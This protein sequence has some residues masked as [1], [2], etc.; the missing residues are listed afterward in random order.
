MTQR[1]RTLA[2]L[3]LAGLVTLTMAGCPDDPFDP[4]TWTKK[5]GNP[6]ETERAVTELERL[7][8][9]VA[10]PA[11]GKA[12]EKLGRPER[13]LAV[14]IELSKP[15][16]EK[17]AKDQYKYNGK[18][19]PASW[20]KSLPILI[21]AIEE[22]DPA[23]PRSVES[24]RLAAEALG[25]AKLDDALE[26]LIKAA[27]GS[28]AKPVRGQAILSLGELGNPGAV[29]TLANI[30]RED[31]DPQNPAM[32]GAAI[33]AL[34]K[35]KSPTAVPVLVEAMYRLP[36][37][38]KQVRRALVASGPTVTDRIKGVLEGGDGDINTLFKDKKLDLY[39]GDVGKEQRPLAD[40]SP[41]SAMDYYA[42]IIAG[43]LY[44]P[45]LVPA[46]LKALARESKPAYYLD[47]AP[48]PPAQNGAL[49]SLRKIG[50]PAAAQAV[51]D[52]AMSTKDLNL[53]P[54]AIGVY[55]FVSTS[56][57]EK[58]GTTTGLDALSKMVAD[59][60][61]DFTV[62]LESATAFARLAR[63]VDRMKVLQ[64]Q[65]KQFESGT[66][67]ARAK[68]DG[69]P[70]AALAAAQAPYDL[71]RADYKKANDAVS[72]A[73]GVKRAATELI[74]KTTE[75]KTALD[76][77][78]KPYN[79]A[80][81]AYDAVDAKAKNYKASQ[82]VFETHLARI[83]IAARCK[84]DAACYGG[85]L[86][87]KFDDIKPKLAP[88]ING[89]DAFTQDE[90]DELL[91]AQI[92]R[93]MLELGKMGNKGVSQTDALLEAAK[94][95]D[96]IVRQSVMLALPKIAGKSCKDCGVKLDAAIAAGE[97]KTTLG[98]LNYET[99][100]LR[101]YWGDKA[102]EAPTP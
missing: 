86:K 2:I 90:K 52:L 20:D 91:A 28:E 13:I 58:T 17:Q 30:I 42:A 98:N 68:A 22:V 69:A 46:L 39:C 33:I 80:K 47:D 61:V 8:E 1:I 74:V 97:N 95:T 89:L 5:L 18:A 51:L 59:T 35:I 21:K 82:R 6:S 87:A 54:M 60:T 84:D 81:A 32:H 43:D 9:P 78:T 7:G 56:G 96:R 38:F 25:S 63:S 15:L 23:N 4:K 48:G 79:E 70:K 19:R 11:L 45:S 26:P 29:P 83:E 27:N 62:R 100:V 76:K 44:D 88:Y 49:D 102:V 77:V 31:F 92:E 14:I 65:V 10:I 66:K 101:S 12:W 16:T 37:F 67:D 57:A 73:G 55:S 50:S 71:A 72:R 94:S 40:C 41:V 3:L 34:G 36:F 85:T 24:A 99:E 75:T 64:D 53:Q 93:A